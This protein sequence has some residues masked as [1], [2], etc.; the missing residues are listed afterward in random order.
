MEIH[1]LMVRQQDGFHVKMIGL[2]DKNC[3]GSP[4]C[5]LLVETAPSLIHEIF[6]YSPLR[7]R[8]I[9]LQVFFGVKFV[10]EIPPRY[11]GIGKRFRTR[12]EGLPHSV[13]N[14]LSTISLRPNNSVF[15]KY[16]E[17]THDY[18]YFELPAGKFEM[19]L[20]YALSTISIP[21]T[22][23]FRIVILLL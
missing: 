17:I 1:F 9:R 5:K 20:P 18:R 3:H 7:I 2:L 23:R 10:V 8:S 13:R 4:S 22:F 19:I 11:F 12:N 6:I 14:R 21:S 16:S 15:R